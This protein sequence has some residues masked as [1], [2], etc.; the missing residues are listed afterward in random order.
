MHEV[1]TGEFVVTWSP[2]PFEGQPDGTTL[3]RMSIDKTISGD[4]IART[5]GR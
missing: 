3:G 1:A 2:L 5:Q 4:L